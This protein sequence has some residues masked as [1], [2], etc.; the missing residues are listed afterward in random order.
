MTRHK[1]LGLV[2]PSGYMPDPAVADRAAAFFSARGWQV[3]A[4]ESMF[5][6]EQRFAGSDDLRLADLMRFATDPAIDVV[7]SGRG[8]YG[9]SRLLD[10]ID[11]ATIKARAPVIAG[12]SDFTAFNLAYLA[13]AGGVSLSGPSAG[14]FGAASPDD[15][16]IEHFFGVIE[17]PHYEIELA[18]GGKAGEFSGRLWGGNL[19]MMV[20]LLGTPYFPRIRGGILV[21]EDVNE[22]AYKL[23]RMFYQLAHAGVLQRQAAIMLGDFDPITPMPNDNGFD[24]A[25]VVA[26]LRE[27]A[28]VPV[29]TGLPYGH[30][31]RKLTLPIGGRARLIV[32]RGGRAA[33]E[34]SGY[35]SLAGPRSRAVG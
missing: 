12:Y 23:E 6:R 21:V 28:G 8:G 24:L 34:L 31:P 5:S 14:D 22:P 9:L 4:G 7:L 10:R 30:T 17:S 27:I 16:T 3:E 15:Y 11:Y 20:A 18:L 32:R 1:V 19:V 29:Y 25:A 33:L 26:R 35:P 13:R 2:A